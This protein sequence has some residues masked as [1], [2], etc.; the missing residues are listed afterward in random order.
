MSQPDGAVLGTRPGRRAAT[1]AGVG[2]RA[3]RR[4]P[5]VRRVPVHA[6]AARRG[7]V[8]ARPVRVAV[9]A[10]RDRRGGGPACPG[11]AR[12]HLQED[13]R[14]IRTADLRVLQIEDMLELATINVA[15]R[16]E[17]IGDQVNIVRSLED[18]DSGASR[19]V[20]R[21]A[22]SGAR[23]K[24]TDDVLREVAETTGTTS[25]PTPPQRWGR[26]SVLPSARPGSTSD[27]PATRVSS[28]RRYRGRQA[29]ADGLDQEATRRPVPRPVPR[30]GRARARPALSPGKSTRSAGSTSRRRALSPGSS[31]TRAPNG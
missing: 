13:G 20:V 6:Q 19:S 4:V 29:S 5:R 7:G 23:R 30:P 11:S 28:A 25:M 24:V 1:C 22:R 27:A 2:R 26:I 18:R 12:R 10:V 3:P 16:L 8:R 15:A 31:S 9:R 17:R 21:R 14:Q